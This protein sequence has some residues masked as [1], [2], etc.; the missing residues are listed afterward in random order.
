MI[1]TGNRG[2]VDSRGFLQAAKECLEAENK[3]RSHHADVHGVLQRMS[4]YLRSHTVSD[5]SLTSV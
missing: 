3:V 5:M 1:D 2:G 4:K